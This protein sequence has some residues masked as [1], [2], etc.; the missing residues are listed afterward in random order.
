MARTQNRGISNRSN[1]V[2][3]RHPLN[4]PMVAAC[5]LHE[6][7][8]NYPRVWWNGFIDVNI[9]IYF[10][11]NT[12]PST[13]ETTNSEFQF[14]FNNPDIVLSLATTTM[15]SDDQSKDQQP[16]TPRS[17]YNRFVSLSNRHTSLE[18]PYAEEFAQSEWVPNAPSL[19]LLPSLQ[20][21]DDGSLIRPWRE[22]QTRARSRAVHERKHANVNA[23]TRFNLRTSQG[24][25][26]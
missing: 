21:A 22:S 8:T 12:E 26:S 6:K 1:S 16:S 11:V 14:S 7:L 25:C 18:A 2:Q 20:S 3:C 13:V 5:C 19:T 9:C 17:P 23:R 15:S 4:G 10:K 24:D